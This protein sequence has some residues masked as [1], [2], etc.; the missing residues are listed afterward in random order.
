MCVCVCLCWGGSK[1]TKLVEIINTACEAHLGFSKV[2][3]RSDPMLAND[4]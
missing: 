1:T 3:V 4:F 2:N